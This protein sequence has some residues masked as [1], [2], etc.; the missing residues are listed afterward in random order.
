MGHAATTQRHQTSYHPRSRA[1]NKGS[2]TQEPW[3]EDEY[4]DWEESRQQYPAEEFD[5][6]EEEV[7]L[8]TFFRRRV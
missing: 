2:N 5:D 8:D 4:N 1:G 3:E 7:D 6:W